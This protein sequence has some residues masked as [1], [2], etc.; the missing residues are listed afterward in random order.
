MIRLGVSARIAN[1]TCKMTSYPN[2]LMLLVY[3]R[4]CN[5]ELVSSPVPSPATTSQMLKP[6]LKTF[7]WIPGVNKASCLNGSKAV[8]PNQR[9]GL[10]QWDRQKQQ[11]LA[12][13]HHQLEIAF[14]SLQIKSVAPVCWY[15]KNTST[16]ALAVPR[17][18]EIQLSICWDSLKKWVI[19]APSLSVW[20]VALQNSSIGFLEVKVNYS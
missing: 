9:V 19:I 18:K 8:S 14:C 17:R 1:G 5:L 2:F 20:E 10:P 3:L 7:L 13:P 16:Q 15:Q 6:G 4:S 11:K 12:P